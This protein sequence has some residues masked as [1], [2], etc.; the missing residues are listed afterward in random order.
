[1]RYV[2]ILA[3]LMFISM[4]FGCSNQSASNIENNDWVL[5]IDEM[6]DDSIKVNIKV[7]F[8]NQ[9]PFSKLNFSAVKNKELNEDSPICKLLFPGKTLNFQREINSSLLQVDDSFLIGSEYSLMYM[10]EDVLANR[11]TILYENGDATMYINPIVNE[12]LSK[13]EIQGFPMSEAKKRSDEIMTLLGKK[14]IDNVDTYIFDISGLNKLTEYFIKTYDTN[15]TL[16]ELS[17]TWI[18]GEEAYLFV[19]HGVIEGN[20]VYDSAETLQPF[21]SVIVDKK[22]VLYFSIGNDMELSKKDEQEKVITAKE[23]YDIAI[24][25]MKNIMLDNLKINNLSLQYII[26]EFNFDDAQGVVSP[27]WTLDY[28]YEEKDPENSSKT[29]IL[30]SKIR[31]NALD[32]RIL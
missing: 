24:K 28:T 4:L 19:Y 25:R 23:A 10:R 14:Q 9:I 1:M 18:P 13:E 7:N 22:G 8:T 6:L 11:Y 27:I 12:Y 5:D 26:T 17:K 20:S 30:E 31:I 16:P 29:K 15:K 3:I 2:K 32:G 21:S